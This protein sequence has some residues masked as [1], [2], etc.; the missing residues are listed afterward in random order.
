MEDFVKLAH[1]VK[2]NVSM[3]FNELGLVYHPEKRDLYND[4]LEVIQPYL[5]DF[6]GYDEKEQAFNIVQAV[7]ELLEAEE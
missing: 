5:G 7:K 2:E 3:N 6:T 1:L 4:L